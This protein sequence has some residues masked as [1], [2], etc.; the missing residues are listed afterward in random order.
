MSMARQEG[1]EPPA[2][3]FGIRRSTIG[4]TDVYKIPEGKNLQFCFFVNSMLTAEFTK[5]TY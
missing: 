1:L 4:A 5:L 2:V 3:G